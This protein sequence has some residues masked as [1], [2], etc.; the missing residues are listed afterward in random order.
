MAKAKTL[1]PEVQEF[2]FDD[3]TFTA[4]LPRAEEIAKGLGRLG[5]TWSCN[6]RANVPYDSLKL[7]KEN[8]LRL[9]LVGYESGDQGILNNVRKGVRLD[10]AR[11]FTRDCRSLG[12][13]IH[14]TF[15][16]GLPGETRETIQKTIRY[17][18]DLDVDTIQVSLA[19]PYPGTEL[20]SQAQHNGWFGDGGMVGSDGTQ[21][22]ILNYPGL[23]SSEI[24]RGL[25]RMYTRF[26]FR[27]KPIVRMLAAMA[28]NPDVRRRRLR[29][30][31]EFLRFLW[32]HG[33]S[34][35]NG[36]KDRVPEKSGV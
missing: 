11:Q 34:P 26:Y 18:C 30:G 7:F 17:A 29:E 20:Y 12:I 2:F 28:R 3:D 15:I 24:T 10:I 5:L 23:P 9:L 36:R 21:N 6:S 14:G 27:P 33:S 4:D 32:G 13:V 8:G 16:L 25:N 22:C 31:A 19:A 35:A 1:F